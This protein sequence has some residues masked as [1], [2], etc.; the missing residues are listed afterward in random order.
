MLVINIIFILILLIVIEGFLRFIFDIFRFI[1]IDGILCIRII[2][3]CEILE[4]L[5]IIKRILIR[6][7]LF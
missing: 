6:L 5:L 4:D 1:N 3:F 2:V 7:I